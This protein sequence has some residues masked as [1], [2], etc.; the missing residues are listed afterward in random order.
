MEKE[1]FEFKPIKLCLK[2]DLVLHPA[3]VDGL[4]NTFKHIYM[5]IHI[6][7]Y[8]STYIY[9]DIYTHIYVYI[10]ANIY[11]YIYIYMY[12]LQASSN[13]NWGL[14]SHWMDVYKKL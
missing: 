10:Y 8:I 7:I 9:I 11:I 13:M 6:H 2:S 5:L 3:G 14:G 1:T 12:I 4:V